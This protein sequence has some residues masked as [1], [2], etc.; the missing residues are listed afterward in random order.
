MRVRIRGPAGQ[1]TISLSETATVEEL[2]TKITE[3]TSISKFDLK[4][5]Y[6]PRPLSLSDYADTAKLS[7]L[8]IKLDGEQLI[9]SATTPSVSKQTPSAN[10]LPK[11]LDPS[12]SRISANTA[13]DSSSAV[14]T[15]SVRTFWSKAFLFGYQTGPHNHRSGVVSSMALQNCVVTLVKR[16]LSAAKGSFY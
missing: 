10:R 9:V 11:P 15:S 7:N 13:L 6:P 16:R 3:K 2:K 8:G 12:L 5:G 4:Y 14:M 1:A